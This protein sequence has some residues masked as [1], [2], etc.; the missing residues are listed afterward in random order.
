MAQINQLGGISVIDYT[1]KNTS[2]SDIGAG[3]AVKMDGSNLPG[4]GVP[5]G[6]VLTGAADTQ[7]LGVTVEAIPNGKTGRVRIMG[8]VP[9][10]CSAAIAP[11]TESRVK[12][13]AAGKFL[14]ATTG[15]PYAGFAISA[16]SATGEMVNVIIN[17][18]TFP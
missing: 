14:T 6:V 13:D 2:G 9:A 17:K 16:T 5:M 18:A 8:V 11:G 15:L 3:L 4:A 1:V 12:V 7:F 10:V